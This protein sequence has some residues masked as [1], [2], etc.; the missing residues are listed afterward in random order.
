MYAFFLVFFVIVCSC[1]RTGYQLNIMVG[2]SCLWTSGMPHLPTD[3]KIFRMNRG[4]SLIA[5]LVN[6][7]TSI[8][9][10]S[11]FA[12]RIDFFSGSCYNHIY[13]ERIAI[14]GERHFT[15]WSQQSAKVLFFF[16]SI[17]SRVH[18]RAFQFLCF[19]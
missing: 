9:K 5:L 17:H 8:E 4:S 10:F 11:F 6:Y 19:A 12:K 2:N 14:S 1:I 16:D 15:D 13:R 7:T 3:E 18:H